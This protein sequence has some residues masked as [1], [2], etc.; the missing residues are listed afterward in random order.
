MDVA[1]SHRPEHRIECIELNLLDRQRVQ[2]IRRTRFPPQLMAQPAAGFGGFAARASRLIRLKGRL[3]D[4]ARIV[5]PLDMDDEAE[6]DESD[7]EELVQ[8]QV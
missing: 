5:G 8:Y 1:I 3:G 2:Q 6:Q 7:Q 4:G